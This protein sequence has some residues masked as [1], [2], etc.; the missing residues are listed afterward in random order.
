MAE[1]DFVSYNRNWA[2]VEK[3]TAVQQGLRNTVKGH[4]SWYFKT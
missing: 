4:N 3:H 1:A 2:T